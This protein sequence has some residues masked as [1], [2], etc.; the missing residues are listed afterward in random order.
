MEP[1]LP[2]R[3]S[4]VF[5]RKTIN[6]AQRLGAA[7][8]KSNR[9]KLNV[10]V[11]PDARQATPVMFVRRRT[12]GLY[13]WFVGC[14]FLA[15]PTLR[16]ALGLNLS[17]TAFLLSACALLGKRIDRQ[18]VC[19]PAFGVAAVLGLGAAL[20]ASYNTQDITQN[21]TVIV[22]LIYLWLIWRPQARLFGHVPRV[23]ERSVA[24][25]V[26]GAA[27]SGAVGLAQAIFGAAL[28]IGGGL[29]GWQQV[30]AAG[31]AG[32]VNDQGGT[33]AVA[34]V[35]AVGFWLASDDRWVRLVLGCSLPLTAGGLIFSGSVSGM[36]SAAFGLLVLVGFQ[37]RRG[38]LR[39]YLLVTASILS[40]YILSL[41]QQS[42]SGISPLTRLISA[43]GE[44]GDISTIAI[45]LQTDELAW[46]AIVRSPLVGAGLDLRS[47]AI[48]NHVTAVH[49]IFLLYWFQG[50]LLLL[51]ALLVVLSAWIVMLRRAP[52]GSMKTAIMAAVGSMLTYAL[53]APVLFERFFWLPFIL[54]TGLASQYGRLL[55]KKAISP[56]SRQARSSGGE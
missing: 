55:P 49:N 56:G 45:R 25:F 29:Q 6:Q 5:P 41:I 3:Y 38:R 22:R 1:N 52:A 20:L 34:L 28:D 17:D 36:L 47:G 26:F 14:L 48:V 53:T 32:H 4:P 37:P 43:S 2:T 7:F 12:V 16:P 44:N 40:F 50:G 35:L 8:S 31:L 19:Q 13:L 9:G 27:V 18:F 23:L 11:T 15:M 24:L 42:A 30:R 46:Q 21:W 39:G 10:S 54:I 33:L 51:V